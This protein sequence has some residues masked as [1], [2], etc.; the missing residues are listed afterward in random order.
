MKISPFS[1]WAKISKVISSWR[2]HRFL[3]ER[4]RNEEKK[5]EKTSFSGS[6]KKRRGVRQ[7]VDLRVYD[8]VEKGQSYGSLWSWSQP[9]I[10]WSVTK[11]PPAAGSRIMGGGECR[12]TREF[13]LFLHRKYKVQ[14][15][16]SVAW[17]IMALFSLSGSN[18]AMQTSGKVSG[19]LKSFDLCLL[20]Q[21]TKS[22]F[23]MEITSPHRGQSFTWSTFS[24]F[25]HFI[26]PPP[27]NDSRIIIIKYIND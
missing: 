11:L 18:V 22:V 27:P 5:T 2:E 7:F 21:R 13:Q 14:G 9:Y 6:G 16:F 24:Y 17:Q 12:G 10:Y 8:A 1:S 4:D 19:W 23:V 20:L 26:F 3:H 15:L 25:H